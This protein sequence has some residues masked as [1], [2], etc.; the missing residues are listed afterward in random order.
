MPACQFCPGKERVGKL[1][2]REERLKLFQ[3]LSEKSLLILNMCSFK[4]TPTNKNKTKQKTNKPNHEKWVIC[5]I[6]GNLGK[7]KIH[8]NHYWQVTGTEKSFRV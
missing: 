1:P 8:R 2:H 3:P 7:A 4:K 6:K 5:S